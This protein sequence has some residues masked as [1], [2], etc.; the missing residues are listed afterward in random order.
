LGSQSNTSARNATRPT[1]AQLYSVDVEPGD[2]I[3]M[4]SDGL[5][6]NLFLSDIIHIVHWGF[7]NN[8]NTTTNNITTQERLERIRDVLLT[9]AVDVSRDREESTPFATNAV[10]QGGY[11]SW[12]GG[13]L[14]DIS[15][16]ISQV[17]EEE[18]SPDRR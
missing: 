8:N 17:V 2:L 14:D 10:D 13:K 12:S 3:I 11:A 9:R 16:V 4:G 5:F 6:D 7:S 18:D 1:D 15:F